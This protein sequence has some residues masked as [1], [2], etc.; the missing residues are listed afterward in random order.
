[1]RVIEI[2]RLSNVN[3]KSKTCLQKN[4]KERLSSGVKKTIIEVIHNE[5]QIIQE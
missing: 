2:M 5:M 4:I 1:M 3:Y